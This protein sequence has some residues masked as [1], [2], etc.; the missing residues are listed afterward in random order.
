MTHLCPKCGANLKVVNNR[1]YCPNHG[2][3]DED[4]KDD[5]DAHRG[6]LG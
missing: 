1:W 4:E 6:Y 3:V 5:E 2:F